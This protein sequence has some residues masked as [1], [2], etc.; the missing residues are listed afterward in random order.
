MWHGTDELNLKFVGGVFVGTGDFIL[1]NSSN[2]TPQLRSS[3]PIYLKFGFNSKFVGFWV[4]NF[5]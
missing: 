3:A 5:S 1:L 2:Y 4:T